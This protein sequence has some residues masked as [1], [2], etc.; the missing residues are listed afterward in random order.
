MSETIKSNPLVSVVIPVYNAQNC[1]GDTIQSILTQSY[2]NI[3]LILVND[4]STDNSLDVL[5]DY[6]A[7]DSRVV[8][9]DKQNQGTQF[10]RQD[11]V[12]IAKGEF[13]KTMDQDDLLLEGAI[14]ALVR[15][16]LESGADMVVAPFYISTVGRELRS[17]SVERFDQVSGVEFFKMICHRKHCWP[18]W[19][20]LHR[21][22]LYIKGVEV[23]EDIMLTEDA[24][25]MTQLA[26][27]SD[28][29]AWCDQHTVTHNLGDQSQSN[30]RKL[31]D[32]RYSRDLRRYVGWISSFI[33]S[34]N[35][36]E[37]LDEELSMLRIR[38]AFESVF[39]GRIED[40]ISD[41]KELR[42]VLRKYPNLL[43][44]LAPRERKIA[45]VAKISTRLSLLQVKYYR[46]MGK[47]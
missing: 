46:K 28:R 47:I 6:A 5:R 3:E 22:S 19:T 34:Q 23:D 9:F 30:Q 29:V 45:S 43:R 32:L 35:L 10:A 13:V 17:L 27:F 11:G 41:M 42:K 38:N 37:E 2:K 24:V 16:A 36:A 21:R 7:K 12:K 44:E 15:R 14:E 20:T 33:A 25:H 39:K 1:V 26:I 31:S 40:F 8:I 4:G 18:V